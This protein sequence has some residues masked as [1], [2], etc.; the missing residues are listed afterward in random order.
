MMIIGSPKAPGFLCRTCVPLLA[1]DAEG[2]GAGERGFTNRP[3][4]PAFAPASECKTVAGRD[5]GGMRDLEQPPDVTMPG[6][7]PAKVCRPDAAPADADR[8]PV[9]G[10]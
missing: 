5:G 4:P 1:G 10:L 7:L 6:H 2:S 9:F 3:R 8:G